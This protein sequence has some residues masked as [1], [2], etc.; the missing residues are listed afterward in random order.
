MSSCV[1]PVQGVQET[2]KGA[3]LLMPGAA[4]DRVLPSLDP[5]MWGLGHTP[6]QSLRSSAA[7]GASGPLVFPMILCL[8]QS[9]ENFVCKTN[10][11]G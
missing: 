2:E 7:K 10:N 3:A 1:H 4:A 8:K 9:S 6:F 11:S 5:H